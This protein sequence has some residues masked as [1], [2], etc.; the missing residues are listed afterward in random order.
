MR[1]VALGQQNGPCKIRLAI[2]TEECTGIP[3]IHERLRPDGTGDAG[4]LI[5]KAIEHKRSKG[6]AA[7]AAGKTLVVF[8]EARVGIWFPNKVARQLPD[9][10]LFA[11]AWIVGLHGLTNGEYVYNA[12]CLISV[13]GDAPAVACARGK[14][15]RLLDGEGRSVSGHPTASCVWK[16][17]RGNIEWK[18]QCPGIGYG[19]R[20]TAQVA[21]AQEASA[22]STRR[23]VSSC[24]LCPPGA[25]RRSSA[26]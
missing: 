22:T 7:Y 26:T 25:S 8:L 14:R 23:V 11:A 9:P 3:T 17:S 19:Q 15:F 20:F 24:C 1:Q 13:D 2:C 12:T 5:L 18:R 16:L 6:S 10:L 21:R 4:A